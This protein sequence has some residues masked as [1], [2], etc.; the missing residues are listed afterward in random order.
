MR[1]KRKRGENKQAR[2]FRDVIKLLPPSSIWNYAHYYYII[3]FIKLRRQPEKTNE[4]NLEYKQQLD[5]LEELV[6]TWAKIKKY[7]AIILLSLLKIILRF[8]CL[9]GLTSK[10]IN[11]SIKDIENAFD[12][13]ATNLKNGASLNTK[14][15]DEISAEKAIARF[16]E[17]IEKLTKRYE[18]N[19]NISSYI[20]IFYSS[21]I[22]F[23]TQKAKTEIVYLKAKEEKQRSQALWRDSF[24][25]R[26]FGFGTFKLAK[27]LL[28]I[29]AVGMALPF[30]INLLVKPTPDYS[31]AESFVHGIGWTAIFWAITLAITLYFNNKRMIK[32]GIGQKVL[33]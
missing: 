6:N 31:S 26:A 23:G 10:S 4:G 7:F 15:D 25:I 21:V 19:D 33:S 32:Y 9:F 5:A 24:I 22:K 18:K 12:R 17:K 20:D 13:Q 30:L 28:A 1:N 16:E 11:K 8:F 3:E 2:E 27:R 14:T 29:L